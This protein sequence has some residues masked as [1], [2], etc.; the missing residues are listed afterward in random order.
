[1]ISEE[2]FWTREE[3]E[4]MEATG[5]RF[6]FVVQT[7]KDMRKNRL[8]HGVGVGVTMGSLVILGAFFLLFCNFSSWLKSWGHTFSMT[9][10]LKDDISDFKRD[11]VD[12]FIRGLPGAEISK[13]ISKKQAMA[14]LKNALGPESVL[15]DRLKRNPLPASYEVIL[16][17]EGEDF[18]KS[19]RVVRENLIN[20]GGVE[21]VQ[22]NREWLKR[23]DPLLK[24]MA[25]AGVFI[26][27]VLCLGVLFILT[28]TMKLIIYARKDEIEIKKLVGASDWFVKRPFVF[29]G[30][31]V[32]AAG[33]IG[34]LL[35]LLLGYLIFAVK[36]IQ[37]L[38]LI[39]L[40]FAFLPVEYIIL[41]LFT[42]I[43]LGV[44][45]SLIAAT[46]FISA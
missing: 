16:E 30:A 44:V 46:R 14:D 6:Y 41:L 39:T 19:M 24:N 40:D 31:A 32:G 27:I 35:I 13:Y 23:L 12:S 42:G 9:V 22:F 26:G 7:L 34:A 3:F 11:R 25:L 43:A 4:N 2:L 20:L 10:Y 1:M 38:G 45:S 28:S 8:V 29:E 15:L 17:G 37:F 33:G 21:E 36:K 5:S 18:E